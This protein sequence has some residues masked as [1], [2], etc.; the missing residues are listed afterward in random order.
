MK[1]Q[2]ANVDLPT[3][4]Q[5]VGA[6]LRLKTRYVLILLLTVNL[7][8]YPYTDS[9]GSPSFFLCFYLESF[10]LSL[11]K[12]LTSIAFSATMNSLSFCS[13]INI[14]ISSLFCKDICIRYR[15]VDWQVWSVP[16][17]H[18]LLH[19]LLASIDSVEKSA[20][21]SHCCPCGYRVTFISGVFK[22]L[23]FSWKQFRTF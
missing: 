14:F 6:F 17:F 11:K 18:L 4:I 22:I 16:T 5:L 23:S 21:Q 19:R 20:I 12:N 1:K 3:T 13:S 9:L 7:C 2:P 8:I 10:F 15:I